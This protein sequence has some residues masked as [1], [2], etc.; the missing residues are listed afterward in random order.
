MLGP[1][2]MRR[3][4]TTGSPP[5]RVAPPHL[6]RGGH[7][8]QPTG[9]YG[10]RDLKGHSPGTPTRP[11]FSR[12]AD[13]A[14]VLTMN[15]EWCRH[16]AIVVPATC[17]LATAAGACPPGGP[18]RPFPRLG[19]LRRGGVGF[20]LAAVGGVPHA[21]GFLRQWL[22]QQLRL[23][24]HALAAE[25]GMGCSLKRHDRDGMGF[26]GGWACWSPGRRGP[27][28]RAVRGLG[29]DAPGPSRRNSKLAGPGHGWTGPALFPSI[30][31]S[32]TLKSCLL[33]ASWARWVDGS[34]GRAWMPTE[35]TT[36]GQTCLAEPCTRMGGSRP[37]APGRRVPTMGPFAA[38][39][40]RRCNLHRTATA[41]PLSANCR[42]RGH[43][44]AAEGNLEPS[45]ATRPHA[46]DDQKRM[47]A[48]VPKADLRAWTAHYARGAEVQRPEGWRASAVVWPCIR[49]V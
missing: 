45:P 11:A 26:V 5:S 3:A 33:A 29:L 15:A 37:A 13:P 14:C 34:C 7:A 27:G 46:R 16:V 28:G 1:A 39:G 20:G 42:A 36:P 6:L 21:S 31:W 19:P 43:S 48:N 23:D 41:K 22:A 2:E 49:D 38:S 17:S 35:G 18:G 9:P 32:E 4:A 10:H 8:R 30:S 40:S 12:H 47:M 25:D 24:H 44:T